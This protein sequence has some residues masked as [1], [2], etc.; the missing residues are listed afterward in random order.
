NFI[1]DE[2]SKKLFDAL[3]M[4]RAA[5]AYIWSTPI[6]SFYTWKVQQ[7]KVYGTEGLG[8][9][10]VFESFNEKQGIVT[11]NLTTPYIISFYDLSKGALSIDYPGGQ[12]A[13]G[14][15]DLWQRPL[16]DMG[17]TGPDGGKGGEYVIYGPEDKG[18]YKKAGVYTYQS[19]TNIVFVGLRLLDPDPE[20]AK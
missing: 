3:D 20:F 18:N 12:T 9:F 14:L 2:S 8:K 4:G 6:V 5:Q 19:A 1:T 10:A 16:S 17:L 13:G 15:M 7:E 11:G